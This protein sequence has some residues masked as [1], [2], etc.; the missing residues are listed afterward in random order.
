MEEQEQTNETTT[1]TE[2]V[3]LFFVFGGSHYYASGGAWDLLAK[4]DD[5]EESTKKAESFIGKY[6]VFEIA[7]WSDDREDDSGFE[8]EWTHV[9]NA[10]DG[11]IVAEF[12]GHPFGGGQP[13][14]QIRE[15]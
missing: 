14:L 6:A 13:V 8:I 4:T 12:G 3:I 2:P 11:S 7:D 5:I 10:Q 9:V 15:K 1:P